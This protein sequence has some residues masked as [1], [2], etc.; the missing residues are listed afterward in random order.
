MTTWQQRCLLICRRT[1]ADTCDLAAAAAAAAA[2]AT[3]CN[4]CSQLLPWVLGGGAAAPMS[5]A[6][7]ILGAASDSLTRLT[8][9]QPPA[10]IMAGFSNIAGSTNTG[11]WGGR[12]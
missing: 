4:P 9:W 7:D 6:T 11:P 8:A 10:H 2:V 1:V 12:K 5:L 3:T